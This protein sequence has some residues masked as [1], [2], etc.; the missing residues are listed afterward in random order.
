MINQR[1][2]SGILTQVIL[3]RQSSRTYHVAVGLAETP[4]RPEYFWLAGGKQ[5]GGAEMGVDLH[6]EGWM[7][8]LDQPKKWLKWVYTRARTV[9]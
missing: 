7:V 4:H 1:Q 9:D 3:T 2:C 6:R 5:K 8:Q